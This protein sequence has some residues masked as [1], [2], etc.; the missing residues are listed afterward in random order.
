MGSR[1]VRIRMAEAL[2][3][4]LR[5]SASD[6]P[7][8]IDVEHSWPGHRCLITPRR[9]ARLHHAP[10]RYADPRR[11]EYARHHENARL[12]G[13]QN[14]CPRNFGSEGATRVEDAKVN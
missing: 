8:C 10:E 7:E 6:R 1:A 13:A 12:V 4:R 14:K 9:E 3:A 2:V 5:D 11:R